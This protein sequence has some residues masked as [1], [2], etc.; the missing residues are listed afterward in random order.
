MLDKVQKVYLREKF[1][2]PYDSN[3]PIINFYKHIDEFLELEEDT[4][5]LKFAVLQVLQQAIYALQ[6]TVLYIVDLKECKNKAIAD[7]TWKIIKA[8][9]P[10]H[11]ISS[12]RIKP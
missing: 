1:N 2:K 5:D 10:T 11:N 8:S 7:K 12:K 3:E 9:S 6:A 4:Y